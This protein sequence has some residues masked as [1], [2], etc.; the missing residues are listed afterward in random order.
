MLIKASQCLP[1]NRTFQLCTNCIISCLIE[2]P[3]S[4]IGVK[5]VQL[6]VFFTPSS[7]VKLLFFAMD[8]LRAR[9]DCFQVAKSLIYSRTASCKRLSLTPPTDS[10]TNKFAGYFHLPPR[11]GFAYYVHGKNIISSA[12]NTFYGFLNSPRSAEKI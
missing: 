12:K 6:V 2:F 5:M 10:R 8:V 4:I 1:L 9:H 7:S 3:F 11:V